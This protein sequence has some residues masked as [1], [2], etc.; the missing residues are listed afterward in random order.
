MN[1]ALSYIWL[2][3]GTMGNKFENLRRK[4]FTPL[5]TFNI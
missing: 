3:L 2:V 4:I 5:T 1:S